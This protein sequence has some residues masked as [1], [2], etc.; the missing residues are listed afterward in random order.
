MDATC[1][2]LERFHARTALLRSSVNC[3]GRCCSSQRCC[4]DLSFHLQDV[5]RS[6]LSVAPVEELLRSGWSGW[7]LNAVLSLVPHLGWVSRLILCGQSFG[8]RLLP[9]L[10]EHLIRCGHHIEQLVALECRSSLLP[11][12]YTC[13]DKYVKPDVLPNGLQDLCSSPN[14]RVPACIMDCVAPLVPRLG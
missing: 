1:K 11:P 9:I 12:L 7:L 6:K 4:A 10:T 3:P 5:S 13:L 2:C 14:F 8:A